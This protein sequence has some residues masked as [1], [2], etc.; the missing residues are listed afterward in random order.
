[1]ADNAAIDDLAAQRRTPRWPIW[2]G[3]IGVLAI[4]G[5]FVA[6]LAIPRSIISP[7]IP[8]AKDFEMPLFDRGVVQLS[9]YHGQVVVLNFW[10]SWCIPCRDEAPVI[11]KLYREYGGREVVFLGVNMQDAEND[12]RAFI[13]EFSLGYPNGRDVNGSIYIL[14]GVAGVPETFIIGTDGNIIRKHVGPINER[15]LR[16]YLEEALQ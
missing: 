9:D 4:I 15:L 12:A 11:E 2:L 5:L 3:W 13:D 7:E 1:M 16:N 14:Y 8:D 10:A 6:G